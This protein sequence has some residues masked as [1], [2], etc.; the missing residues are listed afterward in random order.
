MK[1]FFWMIFFLIGFA[2]ASNA[3]YRKLDNAFESIQKKNFGFAIESFQKGKANNYSLAAY[4]FAQ[5][6]GNSVEFEQ[7]DSAIFYAKIAIDHFETNYRK[8]P[9]R[10]KERFVKLGWEYA[11]LL[12]FLQALYEKKTKQLARTTDIDALNSFLEEPL[13]DHLKQKVSNWRDSLWYNSCSVSSYDCR[14]NL[15]LTTCNSQLKYQLHKEIEAIEYH[16]WV[17]NELEEE[18]ATYIVYHPNSEWKRAAEDKLYSQFL[19]TNDTSEFK[20]FIKN[21]PNSIHIHKIWRAFYELS[22]GNYEASK[23]AEFIKRYP[24]YPFADDVEAELTLMGKSLFPY[25]NAEGLYE[26]GRAHV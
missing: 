2:T 12:D 24:D 9:S 11:Q 14:R 18:L 13:A 20:R 19:A 17:S 25:S 5:I 21:Y 8:L 15:M 23:M 3:Q 22:S 1:A 4:G 6:Y 7:I 16:T 26:I 10:Y